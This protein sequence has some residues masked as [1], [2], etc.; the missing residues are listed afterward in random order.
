MA[1]LIGVEF[2]DFKKALALLFDPGSDASLLDSGS[3]A[4]R[5]FRSF[6]Q[7][8]IYE[9]DD[10]AEAMRALGLEFFDAADSSPAGNGPGGGG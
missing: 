2:E 5:S 7:R 8:L 10:A 1:A 4:R 3:D 6:F 9:S